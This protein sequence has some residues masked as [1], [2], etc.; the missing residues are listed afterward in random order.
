[1]FNKKYAFLVFFSLLICMVAVASVSAADNATADDVAS[2]EVAVDNIAIDSQDDVVADDDGEVLK[3][4]NNEMAN[5][6]LASDNDDELSTDNSSEVLGSTSP[7]YTDYNV[8]FE[9]YSYVWNWAAGGTIYLDIDPAEEPYYYDFYFRVF[10]SNGN[11]IKNQNIYSSNSDD[12]DYC[13]DYFYKLIVDPQC[14]TFTP[15]TYTMKLV[16]YKDNHVFDS[17]TLKVLSGK[18]KGKITI[19]QAGKYA[20]N[21]KL[22]IKVMDTTTKKPIANQRVDLTFSNGKKTFVRTNSNGIATYYM[23][24]FKPGNYF[25]KATAKSNSVTFPKTTKRDNLKIVKTP[26]SLNP[27]SLTTPYASGKYFNIKVTDSAKKPVGGVKL[28]VAIYTGNSVQTKYIKTIST[29]WAKFAASKLAIGYH[30]VVVSVASTNLHTG[31]TKAANLVVKKAL[32]RIYA[33]KIVNAYQQA[34]KYGVKITNYASGDALSGWNVQIKVYTGNSF[35]TYTVKTNA[36]GYASIP[37]KAFTKGDHKIVV[38]TQANQ[39][40]N[41]ASASGSLSIVNKIPTHFDIDRDDI[42]TY[43]ITLTYGGYSRYYIT[44][45]KI[46]VRL[47]DNLGHE[48]YKT[49]T[50]TNDEHQETGTS[51]ETISIGYGGDITIKFAGDARYMP[52][53]YVLEV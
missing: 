49:V 32:V 25:V 14:E 13:N 44:S 10:D 11:Q 41:A 15:G 23:N 42:R 20:T 46:P 47:V 48:L 26:V 12:R 19:Y 8:Q 51:G 16:N 52:C 45:I 34:G 18:D 33:P 28:K 3:S 17:V 39:F 31:S 4:E 43:G 30:K 27:R 36:N 21:K 5:D 24:T 9:E 22:T 6:T 29:G 38:T 50:L 37:T 35:N 53:T 2:E 40:Y 1:M 7:V